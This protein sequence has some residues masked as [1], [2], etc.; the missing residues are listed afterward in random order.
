M[1]GLVSE[2][3]EGGKL[4]KTEFA[5]FEKLEELFKKN[6]ITG[7]IDIIFPDIRP[8]VQEEMEGMQETLKIW[9]KYKLFDVIRKKTYVDDDYNKLQFDIFNEIGIKLPD[10]ASVTRWGIYFT[11]SDTNEPA[12]LLPIYTITTEDGQMYLIPM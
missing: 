7:F 8:V 3:L 10:N 5:F 6:D 11:H 2:E 1:E 4:N 9:S 12:E